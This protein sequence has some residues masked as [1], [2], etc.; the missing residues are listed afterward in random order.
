ML[1]AEWKFSYPAV[2]HGEAAV[3]KLAY[4]DERLQWWSDKRKQVLQANPR[5]A[6]GTAHRGLAVLLRPQLT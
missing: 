2:C 1:R 5:N 4:H 3:A 6:A